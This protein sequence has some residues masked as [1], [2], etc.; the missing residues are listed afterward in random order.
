MPGL[1]KAD[2]SGGSEMTVLDD[3][4]ASADPVAQDLFDHACHWGSGLPAAE[5]QD[6][7]DGGEIETPTPGAQGVAVALEARV[8]QWSHVARRESRLPD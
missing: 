7:V 2:A 6:P 5:D 1:D 8:E 3:D 4:E